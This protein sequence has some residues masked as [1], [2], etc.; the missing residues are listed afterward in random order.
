MPLKEIARFQINHLQV[1]DEEGAL[2][3]QLAPALSDRE[4]TG[5][6]EAMVLARRR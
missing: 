6:H 2:D 3:E 1:L 5:L 4:L